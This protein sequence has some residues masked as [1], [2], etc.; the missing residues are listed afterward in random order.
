MVKP[1]KVLI[2]ENDL[3]GRKEIERAFC[4]DEEF[5]FE[6]TEVA[7]IEEAIKILEKERRFDL[8]VIDWRL[9]PLQEGGLELLKAG[10][11]YFPKIKI[12]YTAY[13]TLE[14]CVKAM[15]AGADDYIDKNQEGSLKKL[16]ESAKE[17]L[18]ARKFEEHEPDSDWLS[19]HAEELMDSYR[20]ELIAFID[21]K[22]VAHAPTNRK[23]A[24]KIKEMCLDE[25][26]FIMF[27]PVEV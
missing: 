19:E 27:A 8:L 21:G 4:M 20:G 17:K 1:R 26:P 13:A 14:N 2:I 16:L 5:D 25:K 9:E 12:V 3:K 24:E 7:E 10:R 23:L 6:V 11:V 22:V 15:Q 18:R